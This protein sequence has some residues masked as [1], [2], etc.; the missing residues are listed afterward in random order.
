MDQDAAARF[1]QRMDDLLRTSPLSPAAAATQRQSLLSTLRVA[2]HAVHFSPSQSLDSLRPSPSDRFSEPGVFHPV[3][4]PDQSGG[5]VRHFE[6]ELLKR[7]IP[8][9][10]LIED[11]SAPPPNGPNV[12]HPIDRPSPAKPGDLIK[13]MAD[14][15]PSQ[16]ATAAEVE[17][18]AV[19]SSADTISLDEVPP[20]ALLPP[21]DSLGDYQPSAPGIFPPH[22]SPGAGGSFIS[23]TVAASSRDESSPAD[24]DAPMSS[25]IDLPPFDVTATFGDDVQ[26]AIER[27]VVSI[28]R[29][30]TDQ[31][32]AHLEGERIARTSARNALFPR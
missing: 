25:S 31:A 12:V 30:Q 23:P 7:G 28:A 3:A 29:A 6:P 13:L 26:Q 9:E 20:D 2:G 18:A 17:S 4:S 5:E 21:D 27:D 15:T 10:L 16:A 24:G 11:H 19:D 14:T 1:Q 32:L 8:H 22:L